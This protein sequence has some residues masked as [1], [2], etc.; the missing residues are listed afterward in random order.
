MDALVNR[1]QRRHPAFMDAGLEHRQ[2]G[3]PHAGPPVAETQAAAFFCASNCS[4][5]RS[6]SSQPR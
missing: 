3:G 1:A 4:F 6:S 2:G 5:M